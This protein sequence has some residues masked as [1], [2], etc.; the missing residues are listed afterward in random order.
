MSENTAEAVFHHESGV[1]VHTT[2]EA[3]QE[4]AKMHP[5][6]VALRTPGGMQEITWREYAERVEAIALGLVRLGV[7]RGDNVGLMLANRPEFNL[8]DTAIAHLGAVPLS[9]YNTSS[10]E[11]LNYLFTDAANR[12][13]ITE[14]AFLPVVKQSG[15]DLAHIIVVDGPAEGALELQEVEAQPD[16]EFDF[17]AAWRAIE[18]D[19]LVTLIYTSGTTGPPKGVELTHR[20]VMAAGE[21]MAAEVDVGFDD[22]TISYLP[23][24]HIA[25][26][27]S[28]HGPNQFRGVQITTVADIREFA[29]ALPDVRPTRS[30]RCAAGVAEAQSRNRSQ[31]RRRDESGQVEVG[32]MGVGC[33][34]PR[35]RCRCGPTAAQ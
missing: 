19:D 4:T 5:D 2:V 21:A 28:S 3:F 8:I 14:Q 18:P 13:V 31:G 9:V 29:S 33:G 10:P 1:V 32:R 6:R 20:N 34:H 22:R 7:E 27:V 15:V 17:Q 25:D 16:D 23:A 30:S 12:I 24:A 35:G 26:R 11:Q